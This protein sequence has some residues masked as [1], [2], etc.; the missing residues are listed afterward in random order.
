MDL[1]DESRIS[2]ITLQP[3]GRIYVFGLSREVL[4]ILEALC[5]P[6]HPLREIAADESACENAPNS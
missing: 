2:E 4:N 5:P 3:D 6:D 1:D